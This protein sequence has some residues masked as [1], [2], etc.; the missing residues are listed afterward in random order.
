MFSCRLRQSVSDLGVIQPP[1]FRLNSYA[2]GGLDGS[3]ILG[4]SCHE[5]EELYL[6]RGVELYLWGLVGSSV[7]VSR[8]SPS[9]IT[10]RLVLEDMLGAATPKS[11]QGHP[12]DIFYVSMSEV[13]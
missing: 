12:E 2:A 7:S 3:A 5:G 9:T 8:R 4:V 11:F 13:Y 6:S 10:E 1:S